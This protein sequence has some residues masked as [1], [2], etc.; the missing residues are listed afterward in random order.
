MRSKAPRRRGRWVRRAR[1]RTQ[2]SYVAF[3][4]LP[5]AVREGELL[6]PILPQNSGC[7]GFQGSC[8]RLV[9]LTRWSR[10]IGAVARADGLP[11]VDVGAVP[12]VVI[13]VARVT[14]A[15]PSPASRPRVGRS[16]ALAEAMS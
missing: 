6:I 15:G 7:A 4:V 8:S 12:F 2:E 11:E 5:P 3:P 16:A 13:V 9:T 1:A 10:L 14:G